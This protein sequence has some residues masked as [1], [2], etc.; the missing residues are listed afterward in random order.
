MENGL[1]MFYWISSKQAERKEN[2]EGPWL[3]PNQAQPSLGTAISTGHATLLTGIHQWICPAQG[4]LWLQQATCMLM[5]PHPS[6]ASWD[7]RECK[8]ELIPGSKEHPLPPLSKMSHPAMQRQLPLTP[9]L[10]KSHLSTDLQIA[11]RGATEV[12]NAIHRPC[13]GL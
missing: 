3:H 2:L 12:R 5:N 11:S 9:Q 6:K 7:R 10:C 4:S 1:G 8:V 13:K